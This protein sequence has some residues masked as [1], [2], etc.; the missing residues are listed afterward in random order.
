MTD[1]DNGLG[2]SNARGMDARREEDMISAKT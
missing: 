2:E 1:F